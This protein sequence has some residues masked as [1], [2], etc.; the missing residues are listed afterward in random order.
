MAGIL[1]SHQH[2]PPLPSISLTNQMDECRL[3]RHGWSYPADTTGNGA[4]FIHFRLHGHT[5]TVTIR[6]SPVGDCYLP[7]RL[8][9]VTIAA[10]G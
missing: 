9:L 7:T 4:S 1:T 3:R 2:K 8:S 10:V 6:R 5:V